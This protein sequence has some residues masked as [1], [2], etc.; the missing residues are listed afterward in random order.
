MHVRYMARRQ[1]NGVIPVA[2]HC[3]TKSQF[4]WKS[5]PARKVLGSFGS[6]HLRLSNRVAKACSSTTR[7]RK[8]PGIGQLRLLPVSL[9]KDHASI[10]KGQRFEILEIPESDLLALP[11][12]S[13][14]MLR[15][16]TARRFH[17]HT[18][19][20]HHGVAMLK[21]AWAQLEKEPRIT[22]LREAGGFEAA[23]S[24]GVQRAA[25]ASQPGPKGPQCKV[26]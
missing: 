26:M 14:R 21:T 3:E 12:L 1:K 24:K 16:M 7:V 22:C 2:N 13:V 6:W 18:V 8:T 9:P 15:R 20:N 23:P 17:Q 19:Q 5:D 10:N 4:S 25:D 11:Q